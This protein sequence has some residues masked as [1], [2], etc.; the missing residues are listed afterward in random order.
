MSATNAPAVL[1][2]GAGPTGLVL[3]S[4]LTRVGV[5]VRLIDEAAEPGTTSRALAV[6]ART[7]ELYQ[8]LGLAETV[9]ERGVRVIAMNFWVGARCVGRAVFGDGG[10]GLS[11][12]PY[13]VIF[14]QDE[15]ERLLIDRLR[16]AGVS[17]ERRVRLLDFEDDGERVRARLRRADGS[18]EVCEASYLAGCDGASSTVRDTLGVGFAGGTYEHL[19]YVA[20]VEARAP[21]NDGQL[22]GTLDEAEFLLVFPLKGE[23]RCRLIGVVRDQAEARR[24]RLTWDDVGQDVMARLRITVERVNWFSTYHVHHRVAG[25]FRTGRAFL[26][27]DAAHIH[28]PVGGQG[29][30]TGIGDAV[31]LAWKLADVL[32]G[33]APAAL[34]DTYEP[35][36]IAF[37]RRLVATTDRA[38]TLITSRGRLARVV[39]RR[40][41][42]V[43]V[44]L[45]F[46]ARAAR[47]LMFQTISQTRLRYRDSALSE[48]WAGRVR[49]G[50]R[51]PWVQAADNFAPL[52]SLTWQVHVYGAASAEVAAACRQGGLALHVFPWRAATRRAGLA[53][54]ALYLVRPDGYVALADGAGRASTLTRYLDTHL[55]ARATPVAPPAHRVA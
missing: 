41:V 52:A 46:R 20:D 17:V 40:L 55:T 10:V 22:H 14:P 48:G 9:S 34:L 24:E 44:P 15:H 27:G 30:N 35:E 33:R 23:R 43:L 45:L 21:A 13:A 32:Q 1:I 49:G 29:M 11:P 18:D 54:D 47:R 26:L 28:S 37:A 31:N 3:A 19:F 4:W 16:D 8:P 2:V 36:R 38:F 5:R 12:F 50:D 7:L 42:P 6:Q 25:R 39:R 51:L 53:R